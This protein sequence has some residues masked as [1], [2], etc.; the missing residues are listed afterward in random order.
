MNSAFRDNDGNIYFGSYQGVNYFNPSNILTNTNETSLY[1]SE[2]KLF[3]EKVLPAQDGSPLKHV[4]SET[5]S[6][7]LKHNQ[8]VFT[9][10]YSGINFT[11]PEKMNLP[12]I[13]KVM[14]NPGTMSGK[15]GV[16]PIPTWMRGTIP[17]N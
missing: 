2:L 5:D 10:E 17:L 12:I 7:I 14:R 13:W 6:I 11:R 3:N 8:S 15:K 16:P 1:L 4:I 9:I